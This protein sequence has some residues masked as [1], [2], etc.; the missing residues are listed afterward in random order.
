MD[1]SRLFT[2]EYSPRQGEWRIDPLNKTLKAN[3]ESFLLDRG[4]PSIVATMDMDRGAITCVPPDDWMLLAL[5]SSAEEAEALAS[6]F[7]EIKDGLER[8]L[9]EARDSYIVQFPGS[10]E[11]SAQ[12]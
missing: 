6:R 5:C 1:A 7:Q 12:R 4:T 8:E 9:Q 10:E 2:V 11:G 3:Y